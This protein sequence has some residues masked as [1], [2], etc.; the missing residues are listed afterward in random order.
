MVTVG[1]EGNETLPMPRED[2]VLLLIPAITLA[3]TALP[4]LDPEVLRTSTVIVPGVPPLAVPSARSTLI[5]LPFVPAVNVC[6]YQLLPPGETRSPLG[7]VLD[8]SSAAMGVRA[9]LTSPGLE[10]RSTLSLAVPD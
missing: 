3:R 5:N 4:G 10:A 6:A 7:K 2:E 8:W 1:G 9:S